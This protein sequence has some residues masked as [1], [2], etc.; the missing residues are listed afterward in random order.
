[1][2]AILR[3]REDAENW[4]SRASEGQ[5][6]KRTVSWSASGLHWKVDSAHGEEVV[7]YCFLDKRD[8]PRRLMSP[9]SNHV[10]KSARDVA[11]ELLGEKRDGYRSMVPAAHYV[12]VDPPDLK[13]TVLMRTPETPR[14]SKRCN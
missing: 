3:A 13:C 5:F 9:G 4:T 12:T 1:M 7:R 11:E 6:T 2:G 8:V 14:S 10:G